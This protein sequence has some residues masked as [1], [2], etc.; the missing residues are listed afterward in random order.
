[1]SARREFTDKMRA[2]LDELRTEVEELERKG[3]VAETGLELEYYTLLEELKLKLAATEQKFDLF[4]ETHDQ[5]LEEFRT[6]LER[7]WDSMR[8]IIRAIT[9]P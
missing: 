1:M 3:K 8:N 2:R 9:G 7:S 4:L 5:A 6:D